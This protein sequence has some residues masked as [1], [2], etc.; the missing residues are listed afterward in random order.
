MIFRDTT[1]AVYADDCCH[2]NARGSEIVMDAI[3]ETI[4]ASIAGPAR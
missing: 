2:L 4:A 1:E 3:A